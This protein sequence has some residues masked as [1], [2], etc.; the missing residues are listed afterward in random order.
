MSDRIIL[1]QRFML[2]WIMYFQMDKREEN[3]L[4]QNIWPHLLCSLFSIFF[5]L[6][7]FL[8][9]KKK[10]KR[11]NKKKA[12]LMYSVHSLCFRKARSCDPGTN[13]RIPEVLPFA[14]INSAQQAKLN[15]CFPIFL[16]LS[17]L[18]FQSLCNHIN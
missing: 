17:S 18:A 12:L 5:N 2:S 6:K 8:K 1:F 16:S 4:S 10:E 14:F 9:N 15:L 7:R 13:H 11:N 3:V